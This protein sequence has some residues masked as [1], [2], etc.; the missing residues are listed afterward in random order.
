MKDAV[1]FDLLVD[2]PQ[3]VAVA[4]DG[5]IGHGPDHLSEKE[6]HRAEVEELQL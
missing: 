2:A 3:S 5:E 1:A 4:L 6:D